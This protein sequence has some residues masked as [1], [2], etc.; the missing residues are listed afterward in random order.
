MICQHC[1]DHVEGDLSQ[2]QKG[3]K[4]MKVSSVW[5]ILSQTSSKENRSLSSNVS[6]Q[7]EDYL[8]DIPLEI[9]SDL[10]LQV[11][12]FLKEYLAL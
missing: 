12:L 2:S 9:T 10:F 8:K 5:N 6:A 1:L 4:Y 11:L 3:T 7:L